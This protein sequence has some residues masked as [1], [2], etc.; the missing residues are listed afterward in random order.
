MNDRR[1][2]IF[3]P[4]DEKELVET[5]LASLRALQVPEG[6]EL[7][8]V[9]WQEHE[10][11][12]SLEETAA[13]LIQG[14]SAKYKIFLDARVSFTAE[15]V[16]RSLLR[17]FRS[18]PQV[19]AIG[20]CGS[21]CFSRWEEGLHRVGGFIALDGK[22]APKEYTWPLQPGEALYADV[23][24]LSGMMLATQY[25]L[26]VQETGAQSWLGWNFLRSLDYADY[27]YRLVV[28]QQDHPWCSFASGVPGW[29][30]GVPRN[31]FDFLYQGGMVDASDMEKPMGEAAIDL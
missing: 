12:L 5:C 15:D 23:H 30:D 7:R 24:H 8:V 26:P 1:I 18:D 27:G 19:G 4:P 22:G 17:I 11:R 28:P 16:L 14:T 13:Q 29:F 2:A 20:V 6:Y 21:R 9:H 10:Q 3:V 31:Y 25:D